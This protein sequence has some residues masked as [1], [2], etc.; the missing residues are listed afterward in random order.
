[1]IRLARISV[2]PFKSLDRISLESVTVQPSGGLRDD[3]RYALC[4]AEGTFINGKRDARVHCI[5]SAFDV[6]TRE[7][8]LGIEGM[9]DSRSFHIQRDRTDV[10]KWFSQ[11]FETA[12][13]LAEE[14]QLGFPDDPGTPGPT[15]ISTA[16]LEAVASWFGNLPLDEVR[17]RFR[18]NLEID[19]VEPFWEDRLFGAVGT[20]VRFSIGA[21][22]LEGTNPCARCV[23]PS[24]SSTSGIPDSM[25]QK[26]FAKQRQASLPGWADLSRFDHF[27]RL[28]VNTR[29]VTATLPASIAVGDELILN[30]TRPA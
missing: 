30:G 16:T 29:P 27:Y 21:I 7:V 20:V 9:N 5:R 23:V 24:R 13:H 18:A 4:D 12:V 11:Y 6:E 3:R 28:A 26:S 15:I 25:F 17:R 8:T 1:M 19:G 2:F 14:T 22:S 10:E